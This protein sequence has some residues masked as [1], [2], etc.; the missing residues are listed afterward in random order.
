MIKVPAQF[1]DASI[2]TLGLSAS[3]EDDP[4]HLY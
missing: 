1:V 2:G 3:M 4:K